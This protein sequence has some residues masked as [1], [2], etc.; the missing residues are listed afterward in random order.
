MKQS[1]WKTLI[2][3]Y[4]VLELE[5]IIFKRASIF[6]RHGVL[7]TRTREN[8][9]ANI[10][11]LNCKVDGASGRGRESVTVIQLTPHSL[12]ERSNALFHFH[13]PAKKKVTTN[14][15]SLTFKN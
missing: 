15:Q 14:H 6:Q 4:A 10:V 2:S 13:F 7:Y 11:Q 9:G 8:T 1:V 3:L 5:Y 12:A